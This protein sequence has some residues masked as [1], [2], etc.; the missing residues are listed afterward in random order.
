M[1]Q[2]AAPSQKSITSPKGWTVFNFLMHRFTQHRCSALRVDSGRHAYT[3]R[4]CSNCTP[5]APSGAPK[6]PAFRFSLGR[7]VLMNREFGLTAAAL[8]GVYELVYTEYMASI[9]NPTYCS[10]GRPLL[11]YIIDYFCSRASGYMSSNILHSAQHKP[12]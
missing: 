12:S 3:Q 5:S 10:G 9:Y 8:S 1:L 4:M 11:P 2:L 6:R 7:H